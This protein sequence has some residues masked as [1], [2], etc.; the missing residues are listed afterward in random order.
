MGIPLRTKAFWTVYHLIERAPVMQ[1]PVERVR[2]ASDRRAM[3]MGLGPSRVVTGRP[4]RSVAIEEGAFETAD[5]TTLPLRIY[6]PRDVPG[7]L[8]VVMNFHGGGFVSG[9][10]QQS[11]W[12]C[13]GIAAQVGAVVVSAQY[14][15]APESAYPTQ[16][17]D[18]YAATVWTVAHAGDLGVDAARLAVMG[19]SAGGTIAA[20]V[21]LMARDRG[22]PPIALQVL[23]YPAVR[24]DDDYPSRYENENAPILT[25]RDLDNIAD[26]YAGETD[27]EDPYLA[28]LFG[29]HHD[30]PPALVQT[31]QHDPLRDHGPAYADALRAAGVPVRLTNYV[32]AVHGYI[33]LPNVTAG[34]RQA[35]AEAAAE[36]RNAFA[37]RT[38]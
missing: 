7:P 1:Q 33:S 35:M 36:L 18:C 28:P 22:G 14:R 21:C 8:P 30:L 15:L 2:R 24:F 12:W 29:E 16:V 20:V 27:L 13:A 6:R 25:R 11:E 26:V 9:N 23:L 19:D 38:P 34:A 37:G 4:D 3:L 5:G 32:G 17:E 31:A 10:P